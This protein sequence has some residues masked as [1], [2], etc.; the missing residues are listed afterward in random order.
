MLDFGL[1]PAIADFG[2]SRILR[3]VDMSYGFSTS[4]VRGSIRYMAPEYA[5]GLKITSKVDV[6]NYGI[7][8]LE[9]VS[10]KSPT[11][12]MFLD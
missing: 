2:V 11:C 10:G 6:Y 7:V 8:L 3:Y 12:E 4:N 1:K 5:A 9:M